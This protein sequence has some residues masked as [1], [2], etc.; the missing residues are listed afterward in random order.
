MI[1]QEFKEIFGLFDF[2]A[3]DALSEALVYVEGFLPGYR[4]LSNER[5]LERK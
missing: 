5:M 2:V 3:N 1:E 4:V